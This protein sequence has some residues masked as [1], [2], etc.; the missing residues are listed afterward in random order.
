ML[1]LLRDKLSSWIPAVCFIIVLAMFAPSTVH[2]VETWGIENPGVPWGQGHEGF[3]MDGACYGMVMAEKLYHEMGLDKTRLFSEVTNPNSSPNR[4][5]TPESKKLYLEQF[6]ALAQNYALRN[7]DSG[8]EIYSQPSDPATVDQSIADAGISSEKPQILI[9]TN[10]AAVAADPSIEMAG[11]AVLVQDR[12]ETDET[13]SYI[14]SDPNYPGESKS[15]TYDKGTGTFGAYEAYDTVRHDTS[16]I[17]EQ[18]SKWM[19]ALL[20]GAAQPDGKEYLPVWRRDL[21]LPRPPAYYRAMLQPDTEPAAQQPRLKGL[22]IIEPPLPSPAVSNGISAMDD[23]AVG[24]VRLYF[25]PT[26][27]SNPGNND[28]RGKMVGDLVEQIT[29]G[30][31]NFLV[32]EGGQRD[33]LAVSLGS[34]LRQ[35]GANPDLGGLTRV[36]GFAINGKTGDVILLGKSEDGAPAITLDML[37]VALKVS[38]HEKATPAISLD[39]DTSDFFGP[40]RVRLEGFPEEYRET[41]F[42]SVML[43][44]DYAMKRIMLGEDRLAIEG[45]RSF[46]EMIEQ[47]PEGLSAEYFRWWLCPRETSG[48]SVYRITRGDLAVYFY[49]SDV[50]LLTETMKQ[51]SF[52]LTGT[53]KQDPLAER[54]SNAFTSYYSEI[55]ESQPIFRRLHGLFDVAKLAAILRAE[56]IVNGELSDAAERTV[57]QVSIKSSYDGIGPKIISQAGDNSSFLFIGGGVQTRNMLQKGDFITLDANPATSS[58]DT[59]EQFGEGTSEVSIETPSMMHLDPKNVIQADGDMEAFHALDDIMAG[60]PEKAIIR[61]DRVLAKEPEHLRA[62]VVRAL[63][64]MMLGKYAAAIED[65]NIA[66][67]T[68]PSFIGFRGRIRMTSGDIDGGMA[69]I[70]EAAN[71]F[72]DRP[73]ILMQ[74]TWANIQTYHLKE[75]MEDFVRVRTMMPLDPDVEKMGKQL[76]LLSGMDPAQAK[77]FLK[78]QLTM[79]L[80]ISV[81]LSRALALSTQGKLDEAIGLVNKVLRT[82]Q[83]KKGG[84]DALYVEERCLLLLAI[85]HFA[86]DTPER[87]T[88]ARG[89]LAQ[90]EKKHPGWPS[91]LYYR[92]MLDTGISF[93]QAAQIYLKAAKMPEVNDRLML[94]ARLQEGRNLKA[95]L[96]FQL[97]MA[98]GSEMSKDS[99]ANKSMIYSIFDYASTACGD[100]VAKRVLALV[101]YTLDAQA[102]ELKGKGLSKT[103]ME[104][105][106]REFVSGLLSLPA[107]RRKV[108]A[109]NLIALRMITAII[110][111]GD[112]KNAANEQEY[113]DV[114]RL[115]AAISRRLSDDWAMTS[116]LNEA[117]QDFIKAHSIYADMLIRKLASD[118]V[119]ISAKDDYANGDMDLDTCADT[120]DRFVEPIVNEQG[121]VSSLSTILLRG[122]VFARYPVIIAGTNEAELNQLIMLRQSRIADFIEDSAQGLVE[123]KAA[124]LWFEG[125]SSLLP[126]LTDAELK[127]QLLIDFHRRSAR[128]N[129]RFEQESVLH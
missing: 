18:N 42:T 44:A 103:E 75:A 22:H 112:S 57:E 23:E 12:Q 11:H 126:T 4:K 85:M 46:A 92:V 116:S 59:L 16:R 56:E 70:Q 65:I 98:A 45:Y 53:G 24:G 69:D 7:R 114:G 120:I 19:E 38:W 74:R 86:D 37:S 123:L 84:T 94:E 49:D 47:Q 72:P 122:F 97:A 128:L 77:A 101:R 3:A 82:A 88:K 36:L 91:V 113:N 63:A 129:H 52:G 64:G 1:S 62:R 111:E 68:D 14:I 32:Q 29:D 39:P 21:D 54:A 118:P 9:L 127:Q 30:K 125:L 2:A 40:Q 107:E 5:L 66:I 83:S 81:D 104:N 8:S 99:S 87:I 35:E 105:K 121:D 25:D 95:Q 60:A 76:R 119:I 110:L 106:G 31:T 10:H 90:L 55:E 67:K 48:A 78:A 26:I 109:V 34:I 61:L 41:E 51:A 102:A 79:P 43:E 108:D 13:V 96:G 71:A 80:S 50:K 93:Q 28:A 20:R 100:G 6:A 15:I 33:L 58:L 27:V 124:S 117:A 17:P 73:D 115:F 89:Y